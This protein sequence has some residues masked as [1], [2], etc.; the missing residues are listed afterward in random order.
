MIK[1]TVQYNDR[2]RSI[3]DINTLAGAVNNADMDLDKLTHSN[4][5]ISV[6]NRRKIKL[7]K[8]AIWSQL[9]TSKHND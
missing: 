7:L 6:K 4:K 9:D 1:I 2:L 3:Y 8:K 5:N